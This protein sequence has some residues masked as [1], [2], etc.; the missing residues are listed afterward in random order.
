M[1]ELRLLLAAARPPAPAKDAVGRDLTSLLVVAALI[2]GCSI[3]FVVMLAAALAFTIAPR[4]DD[5]VVATLLSAAAFAVLTAVLAL[6]LR[7]WLR[8]TGSDVIGR[9]GADALL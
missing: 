4:V 5:W 9:T 3:A 6:V 8:K 2:L 1:D 7:Q